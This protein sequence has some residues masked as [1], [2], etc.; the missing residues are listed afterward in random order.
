MDFFFEEVPTLQF[1]FSVEV[2]V[3]TIFEFLYSTR[4]CVLKYQCDIPDKELE[5][6]IQF[7]HFLKHLGWYDF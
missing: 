6:W 1:K 5:L 4:F 3:I 7:K 2:S